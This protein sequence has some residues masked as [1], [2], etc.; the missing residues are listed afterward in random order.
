LFSA[1]KAIRA[2][3]SGKK[4]HVMGVFPGP[5]DTDM[6]KDFEAEKT[7]PQVVA[8]AIAQGILKNEE[9]VFPDP[10]SQEVG[11]L[12]TRDPNALEKQFSNMFAPTH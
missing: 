2:E 9:N 1:T 12:W 10:M 3:L 8:Q 5:I 7:S 4:V 11:Q 6:A